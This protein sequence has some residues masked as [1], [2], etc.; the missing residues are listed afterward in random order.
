MCVNNSVGRYDFIQTTVPTD[1]L[2]PPHS[3]NLA[4]TAACMNTTAPL[5]EWLNKR[6]VACMDWATCWEPHPWLSNTSNDSTAI[7]GFKNIVVSAGKNGATA[8]GLDEC[9]DLEGPHWGH[10]PGC[11]M[12]SIYFYCTITVRINQ[13]SFKNNIDTQ[14]M[15]VSLFLAKTAARSPA[16]KS[17]SSQ[18]VSRRRECQNADGGVP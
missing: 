4:N 10:I 1:Y 8:I 13:A 6:G 2:Y 5:T 18:S 15:Q 17:T 9:G 11:P 7:A 3:Y 12:I 16:A 14:P